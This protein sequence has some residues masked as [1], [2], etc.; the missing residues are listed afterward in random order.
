MPTDSKTIRWGVIGCGQ[1]AVDKSIPGLLAAKGARLAAIADP[2]EPRRA[3]ALD[4]A[5]TTGQPPKAYADIHDLLAD[6]EIDA[7]YISL[8]TGMHKDAVI[9]AAMAKKA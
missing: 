9:A 5:A 3:L 7:V 4:L 6:P 8:P 1:I 2:L